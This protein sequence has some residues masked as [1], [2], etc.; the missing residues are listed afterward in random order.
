MRRIIATVLG[1]A[2]AA[3]IMPATIAQAQKPETLKVAVAQRGFWNSSFVEFA[4]RQGFFKQEGLEL[5]ILYTQGGAST[6]LPVVSG[7]IDVA[8]TNGTLG[9]IGAFA[10]GMPVKIISA[11]ATGAPDAF[12]YARA[13]SDIKSIKDT[14]GKTVA[15]SSPGSSTNLIILQLVAQEKA[16]PKLVPTGGA[17]GT[18]TQVMTGQIDVGWSVPPFVLQQ[19]ADGKA[20]IIARGS[21]VASI[22]NQT[23]RV[24]VANANSLKQKRDALTRY[25]RALS[26][27]IDW[28]YANAAAVDAYAEIAKVPRALAQ[29]TRD[30]FYP[31]ES[32]QL[33]EVKGLD[34]TLKQALEF[35]YIA[36]PLS[37]ADVQSKLI[38]ILY[39]P[40]K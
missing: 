4:Q 7:S 5:E 14:N 30:D 21:D 34:L 22:R 18:L 20:R 38:D 9:V 25:I 19:V 12:W 17:P 40:G 27:A 35:K 31:K 15:F 11:E 36:S 37:V 26:R 13:E 8:M 6:L 32:L 28:A 3:A 23:I 1:M 16:T 39:K 29:R 33:A 10:K 24:N 2:V